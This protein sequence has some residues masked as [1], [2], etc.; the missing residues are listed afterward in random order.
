[1]PTE[2]V[3]CQTDHD[4]VKLVIGFEMYMRWNSSGKSLMDDKNIS[5]GST[6]LRNSIID[7]RAMAS[8]L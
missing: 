1:M 6:I 3:V 7:R 2:K 8:L 4:N 5:K